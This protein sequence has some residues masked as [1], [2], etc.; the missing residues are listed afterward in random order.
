[1][2]I[3]KQ[4]YAKT[5]ILLTSDY[6]PNQALINEFQTIFFTCRIEKIEL[7]GKELKDFIVDD[8]AQFLILDVC[9]KNI[10]NEILNMYKDDFSLRFDEEGDFEPEDYF[11]IPHQLPD[12]YAL[13]P[14]EEK[15][16]KLIFIVSSTAKKIVFQYTEYFDDESEGKTYKLKYKIA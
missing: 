15:R 13:K 12:E 14:L 3:M 10:T 1:M 16:G 7:P 11:G 5:N 9:I 4:E 2:E 8:E 6:C